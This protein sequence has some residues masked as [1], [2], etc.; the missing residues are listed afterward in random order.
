MNMYRGS[1]EHR[2]LRLFQ[3]AHKCGDTFTGT[4]LGSSVIMTIDPENVKTVLAT[5]FDDFGVG[6][7]EKILG[8]LAGK[9]IFTS[10]K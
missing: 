6:P 10:G 2:L 3:D 1:N 5:A 7:R 9:G 8:P 4:L